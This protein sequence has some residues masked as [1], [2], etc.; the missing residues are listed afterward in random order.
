MNNKKAK[1]IRRI[2]KET[3][4]DK[5]DAEFINTVYKKIKKNYSK[6]PEENRI[7]LLKD[8]E[9]LVSILKEEV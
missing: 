1:Q 8:S 5:Y 2:L 7:A 4:G 3:Y 9:F 6:L